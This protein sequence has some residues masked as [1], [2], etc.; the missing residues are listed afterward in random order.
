[1]VALFVG[2]VFVAPW[3]GVVFAIGGLAGAARPTYPA[4]CSACC[5]RRWAFCGA[6][7]AV[8]QW[9][10]N[11]PPTFEWPTFFSRVRTL[12]WISILFLAGDALVESSA[13]EA[14]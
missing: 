9:H 13:P 12:G 4:V 8:K 14:I 1:M 7:I 3:V 2:G 5:P 6:Y 11:F 10:T